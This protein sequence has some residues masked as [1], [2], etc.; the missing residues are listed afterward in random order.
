[1]SMVEATF[2]FKNGY[3][4]SKDITGRQHYMTANGEISEGTTILLRSVTFGD[5]TLYNVKASVVASQN[6]PLLLGQ[7]VF[8]RLGHIEIDNQ[9]KVIRIKK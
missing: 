8:A 6:A 1:M 2:M 7:S 4:S 5:I 3:L 9:K